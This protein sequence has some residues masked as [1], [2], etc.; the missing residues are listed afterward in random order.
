METR[1]LRQKVQ[2]HC[3]KGLLWLWTVPMKPNSTQPCSGMCS[4]PEKVHSSSLKSQR[5]TRRE[6]T[7]VLKLHTI[8][9][10]P[11]ST[12][13]K[14]QCKSQTRLCTTVLWV[15]QWHKPQGELSTNWEAGGWL[16]SVSE[17]THLGTTSRSALVDTTHKSIQINIKKVLGEQEGSM[18]HSRLNLRERRQSH[19]TVIFF[20]A[21]VLWDG[22]LCSPGWPW[23]TCGPEVSFEHFFLPKST[24]GWS[25]MHEPPY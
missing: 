5:P 25:H 8:K 9:K 12:C 14:P 10:P 15:T 20:L 6:A 16:L 17:I 23:I 11:P 18:P 22:T 7:E 2:W 4:I 3:L 13:R 19:I 21:F 1:W 24:V